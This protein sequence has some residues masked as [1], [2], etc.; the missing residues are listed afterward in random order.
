[1]VETENQRVEEK[2]DVDANVRPDSKKPVENVVWDDSDGN[3]APGGIYKV[4]VH[5][6]KK[7]NKRGAKDPTT[8]K[9]MV[10]NGG[11]YLEYEDE[12]TFGDPIK[13]ICEFEVDPP[14]VRNAK[15]KAAKIALEAAERGESVDLDELTTQILDPENQTNH[16]QNLKSSKNKKERRRLQKKT[17]PLKSKNN[18]CMKKPELKEKKRTNYDMKRRRKTS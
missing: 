7:H 12:L 2:L 6:Y 3:E 8:F 16:R 18:A 14:H 1:M 10:N 17:E 9:I 13:L 11:E 4:Y 5:Y 15:K